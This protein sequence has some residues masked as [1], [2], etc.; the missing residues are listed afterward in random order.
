R[1]LPEY[2]VPWSFVTLDPLPV[3]ANGKLD[4]QALPAPGEAAGA[5][6]VAPRKELE[7]SI[8]AIWSEVL[9]VERVGIHDD[10][11]QLG[12]H[13]LLAPQMMFRVR[14]AFGVEVPLRRLF[15]APTVVELARAVET[16]LAASQPSK[17]PPAE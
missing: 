16:A 5:A 4:R 14:E 9:G 1:T 13:S 12:G 17:A 3:T 8:A 2:M 7:R 15:E 6:Y 10:F 11:F